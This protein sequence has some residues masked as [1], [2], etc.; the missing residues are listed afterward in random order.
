VDHDHVPDLMV[1]D[2][3]HRP[4]G[5]LYHLYGLYFRKSGTTPP[6]N[7]G[8]HTI[9]HKTAHYFPDPGPCSCSHY[10]I[11]SGSTDLQPVEGDHGSSGTGMPGE[12]A[13]G[14]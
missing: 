9:S 5:D 8:S 10:R 4:D 12:V 2:I 1:N 6:G 7:N 13:Y 14:L 3:C 11:G